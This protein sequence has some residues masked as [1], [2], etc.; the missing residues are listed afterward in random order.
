[1][2]VNYVKAASSA[3]MR[4]LCLTI[5]GT[6][7]IL[8]EVPENVDVLDLGRLMKP[9]QPEQRLMVLARLLVQL[10]PKRIHM[11]NDLVGFRCLQQYGN[12]LRHMSKVFVSIFTDEQ[13]R[14]DIFYGAGVDYLREFVPHV[15]KVITDNAVTSEDWEKRF[16]L[17]K[18]FFHP[19]YGVIANTDNSWSNPV[20]RDRVL[21][22]GR[23]DDQKRLDILCEVAEKLPDIHFD[24]YGTLVLNK[25]LA[26]AN[27]LRALSNVTLHGKYDGFINLPRG[28]HF[29]LLYTTQYDGLP[30]VLLEAT[31]AGLPVI[32][33][34]R[35]GIR[36]FITNKTG[37]L[38]AN[39]TDIEAYITALREVQ[40]NKEEAKVRWENAYALITERHSLKKFSQNL[41]EAYG[42]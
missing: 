41:L 32:A 17:H 15:T 18:D 9:L 31:A 14:K 25:K 30:N 20:R 8:K 3:G 28:K 35:G 7:N 6:P 24:V 22:A 39:N 27:S 38:I 40:G 33:P 26:V 4:V 29:A 1:M 12:A 2:T 16:G 19:V 21:W 13:D 5:N 10:A 11:V 34:D 42:V 36:D 23:L 37:W